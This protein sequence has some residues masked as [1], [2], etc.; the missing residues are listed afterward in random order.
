MFDEL[1]EYIEESISLVF[2]S[3][4]YIRVFDAFSQVSVAEIFQNS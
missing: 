2:N 3:S 1:N 4:L